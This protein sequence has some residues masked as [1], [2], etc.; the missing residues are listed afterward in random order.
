MTLAQYLKKK[1]FLAEVWL[2]LGY[3]RFLIKFV[4]FRKWKATLGPINGERDSSSWPPLSA[5]REA[6]AIAIG[7]SVDRIANRL[8]LFEAV[9]LPRAMA[10]RWALARRGI[11]SHI[12]IG[13]RRGTLEEGLLFH[14]WLMVGEHVLTGAFE[15][16]QFLAFGR[17]RG[18]PNEARANAE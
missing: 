16:D 13:S 3:A 15:R 8:T 1:L 11:D 9:C 10:G 17:G 14:A 7:R 12:V 5:E 4:P 2:S 6:Q 18:R